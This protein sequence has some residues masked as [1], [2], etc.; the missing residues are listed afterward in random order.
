MLKHLTKTFWIILL[1]MVF[2]TAKGQLSFTCELR[3]DYLEDDKNIVFDVYMLSTGTTPIEYNNMQIGVTF[4]SAIKNGGTLSAS[5]VSGF[6][7]LPAAQQWLPANVSIV[8][9]G[10][11]GLKVTVRTPTVGAGN[12]Y[13][14]STTAPGTRLARFRITNSVAFGQAPANFA[15]SFA[16][17]PWPTK[18]FAYLP[19]ATNITGPGPYGAGGTYI[20]TSLTNPILN[21]PV[22]AYTIGNSGSYCAG[23]AGLPITLSGSELGVA[24]Q[25][26][27]D[28]VNSGSPVAG[29][30]AALNFG[31]QT[32]GVY[33]CS[34]QRSA[35]YL[36]ATMTGSATLTEDPATVGGSV[37]GGTTIN[38]GQ[39]SGLLTLA[40]HVGSIVKWQFSINDGTDW[41]DIANTNTTYTSGPLTQTTWFRAVVQSGACTIENSNHTVVTV[42]TAPT[43]YNVSGSGSY[44]Q[45]GSGLTVTLS[46][47]EIGVNYQLFK[48]LVAS[49]AV[50]PGTGVALTW[51]NQTAG[52]YTVV[53]TNGGMVSSDMNG[54]AV[55]T[56]TANV[57]VSVALAAAAN[58][59]CTGTSVEFTATPTN[60]GVS[61]TYAWYVNA[62][63]MTSGSPAT[64]NYVPANGDQV[65]VVLTSDI[66]CV[67]G[68]PATSSTITMVVNPLLPVSVTV[69][70]D[71]NPV[72]AGTTV[73]FTATPTNGGVTPATNGM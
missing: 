40:G 65:Y 14:I 28:A 66:T 39:T 20:T 47:S 1:S 6:S 41:T 27:K 31:N 26:I 48:D 18:T 38:S 43:V 55:I 72:C 67:T 51:T 3:N 24:Y 13:I 29:T 34:A 49:G 68:N 59:V 61:P 57:P 12:G 69:A 63:L 17:N 23:S 46:G 42:S 36:T 70:A 73:I 16:T 56:E 35:T 7:D 58:N 60:G 9:S 11:G 4:N 45:G 19:A 71:A 22:T 52:S 21:L 10:T 30:A 2:F 64:Y 50:V 33:T 32:A 44:C 5:V 54:A 15:W 37:T 62:T 53:G 25:L 8:T